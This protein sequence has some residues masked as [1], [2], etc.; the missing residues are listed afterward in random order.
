MLTVDSIKKDWLASE[1]FNHDLGADWEF[2]DEESCGCINKYAIYS[3]EM[4]K[5]KKL[6]KENRKIVRKEIKDFYR[7]LRDI[8]LKP[9]GT[10]D[11]II[12]EIQSRLPENSVLYD[13]VNFLT[14]C[15]DFIF[16]LHFGNFMEDE[17][18]KIIVIDPVICS[19][20]LAS[21]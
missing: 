8:P 16:D 18:G 13:V 15:I 19:E 4:K 2:V 6:S 11:C 14:N 21:I 5:L 3:I 17:N 7:I 9:N 1:S 12:A 10:D 20:M